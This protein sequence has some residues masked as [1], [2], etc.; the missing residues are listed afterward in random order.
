MIYPIEATARKVL[1]LSESWVVRYRLLR[2]V[3][4]RA[5]DDPEISLVKERMQASKWVGYLAAEQRTDG[6]WGRF[7]SRDARLK[8]TIHTTEVGVERAVELGLDADH[9]ILEKAAVY[10]LKVMR[11]EIDFPDR[12]E[13]NDR[14]QTGVRLFLASTLAQIHPDHPELSADRELWRNIAERTFQSGGYNA[15]DEIEAHAELTGASVRDSYL[16]MGNRYQLTLLGSQKGVLSEQVETALLEWLW[17]RPQGIGYLSIPLSQEPPR[18]AGHVDRWLASLELLSRCFPCWAQVAGPAIDWL[19]RQRDGQGLWD[20]GARP[21][22]MARLPLSDD[23]RNVRN[24]AFDW[25]TRILS[26]LS[27]LHFT[28]QDK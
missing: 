18:K 10:I 7:H 14:W 3:F 2:D 6:G 21:D 20:F 25:T 24:R 1:E 26:L 9:P 11:G 15:Q 27:R 28:S 16:V 17:W 13:K 22:S 8:Q 4:G 19:W 12:T 5:P 23:W